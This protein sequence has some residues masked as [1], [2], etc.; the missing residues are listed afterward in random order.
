MESEAIMCR[1][2]DRSEVL[3]SEA[4][5][6]ARLSFTDCPQEKRGIKRLMNKSFMGLFRIIRTKVRNFEIGSSMGNRK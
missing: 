6:T 3:I 1:Y 5:F 2:S 4:Y